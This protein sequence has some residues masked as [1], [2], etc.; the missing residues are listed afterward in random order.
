MSD[1][2]NRRCNDI[3]DQEKEALNFLKKCGVF[4]NRDVFIK[5][6]YDWD[7]WQRDSHGREYPVADFKL[8]KTC[9]IDLDQEEIK[10]QQNYFFVSNTQLQRYFKE[11]EDSKEDKYIYIMHIFT[12][13]R[14]FYLNRRF[15]EVTK[16]YNPDN[17]LKEEVSVLI[18]SIRRLCKLFNDKKWITVTLPEKIKPLYQKSAAD[19]KIVKINRADV[20]LYINLNRQWALLPQQQQKIL[21]M[22][23]WTTG[24]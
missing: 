21:A 23:D 24:S 18:C 4:Q 6:G 22:S 3:K 19:G 5:D 1:I 13:E 17:Y 7:I 9:F 11:V 14:I 16:N 12:G 20:G 2:I 15:S 10:S 8:Q